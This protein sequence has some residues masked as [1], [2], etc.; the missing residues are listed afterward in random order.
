MTDYCNAGDGIRP[1]RCAVGSPDTAGA[2]GDDG[3]DDDVGS[4]DGGWPF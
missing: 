2:G 1:D 4:F 3:D